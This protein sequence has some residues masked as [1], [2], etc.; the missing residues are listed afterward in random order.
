MESPRVGHD[1]SDLAAAAARGLY[2]PKHRSSQLLSRMST[3]IIPVF[4][5]QALWQSAN[6]PCSICLVSPRTAPSLLSQLEPLPYATPEAEPARTWK[7]SLA[8]ATGDKQWA[9]LPAAL[10]RKQA[11]VLPP[12]PVDCY[13]SPPDPSACVI[14]LFGERFLSSQKAGSYKTPIGSYLAVAHGT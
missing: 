14:Y 6:W 5:H 12:L 11:N 2:S 9:A 10:G 3:R 7:L 1:W 8:V 13:L 4:Q